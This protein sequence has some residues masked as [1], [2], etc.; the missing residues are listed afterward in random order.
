MLEGCNATIRFLQCKQLLKQQ[1]RLGDCDRAGSVH[2]A[3]S[4]SLKTGRAAR[5]IELTF[6]RFLNDCPQ[7]IAR[8]N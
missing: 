5:I 1:I 8:T 6:C 4:R 2:N 7:E 3:A